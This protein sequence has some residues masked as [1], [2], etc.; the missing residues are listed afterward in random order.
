MSFKDEYYF[1]DSHDQK[2]VPYSLLNLTPWENHLEKP[3]S[4]FGSEMQWMNATP[5]EAFIL[6][7]FHRTYPDRTLEKLWR[8][9]TN[10]RY[11]RLHFLGSH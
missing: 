10:W 7:S 11:H 5:R 1:S 2:S 8:S 6:D 3:P 4:Q 9:E